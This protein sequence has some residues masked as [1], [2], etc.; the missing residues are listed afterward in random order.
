M[1]K[2]HV[3][4]DVKKML[5]DLVGNSSIPVQGNRAGIATQSVAQISATF[6]GLYYNLERNLRDFHK[7][8]IGAGERARSIMGIYSPFTKELDGFIDDTVKRYIL[9]KHP[10]PAIKRSALKE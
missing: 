4:Q 9:M 8:H 6:E 2:A 7:Q 3:P 5:L 10:N 1:S